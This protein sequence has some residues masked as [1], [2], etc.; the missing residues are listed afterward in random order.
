MWVNTFRQT[1]ITSRLIH[2]DE[3]KFIIIW[4]RGWDKFNMHK[5]TPIVVYHNILDDKILK[6]LKQSELYDLDGL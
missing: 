1:R 2:V 6:Y 5:Y 3:K 4:R